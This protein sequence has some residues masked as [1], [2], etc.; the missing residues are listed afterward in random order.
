MENHRS[1]KYG[2]YIL[3]GKSAHND[4]DNEGDSDA[5]ADPA[6]RLSNSGSFQIILYLTSG[7]DA[8]QTSRVDIKSRRP[9]FALP[10]MV[11]SCF[12]YLRGAYGKCS[13]ASFLHYAA[14]INWAPISTHTLTLTPSDVPLHRAVKH[15]PVR[16]RQGRTLSLYHRPL[17]GDRPPRRG[18][19]LEK[20]KT[21][22]ALVPIFGSNPLDFFENSFSASH[23]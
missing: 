17:N 6:V 21:L 3:R 22:S 8:V 15:C 2:A 18:F 12:R 7:Q 4:G 13:P 5:D 23:V 10:W 20:I 16:L 11:R 9:C 14:G 1:L 19:W